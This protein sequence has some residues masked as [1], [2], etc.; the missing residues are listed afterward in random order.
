MQPPLQRRDFRRRCRRG[1]PGGFVSQPKEPLPRLH[2]RIAPDTK[3]ADQQQPGDQATKST[4]KPLTCHPPQYL[5]RLIATPH[6]IPTACMKI[7]AATSVLP[8]EVD[9]NSFIRFGSLR[10]ITRAMK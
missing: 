2:P 8:I 3:I 9:K 7:A 5:T 4:M 6:T 1:G 10:H